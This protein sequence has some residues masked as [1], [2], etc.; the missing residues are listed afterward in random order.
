MAYRMVVPPGATGLLCVIISVLTIPTPRRASLASIWRRVLIIVLAVGAVES[1]VLGTVSLG[2]RRI[3]LVP[4]DFYALNAGRH[5]VEF[6][7]KAGNLEGVWWFCAGSK[8]AKERFLIRPKRWG[9]FKLW[10]RCSPSSPRWKCPPEQA[11]FG[12]HVAVPFWFLFALLSPYPGIA[13][14]RWVRRHRRRRRGQCLECGYSL[15][16]NLSGV[17]PEC[18]SAVTPWPVTPH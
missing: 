16:A 12:V 3:V 13:F 14:A 5:A 6:F 9:G 10:C 2:D 18:G 17:C 8:T 7:F 15:V 1:L 4:M 11:H